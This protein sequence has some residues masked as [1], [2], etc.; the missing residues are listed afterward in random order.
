MTSQTAGSRCGTAMGKFRCSP[1]GDGWRPQGEWM[2]GGRWRER[3]IEKKECWPGAWTTMERAKFLSLEN[4]IL[5]KFEG[6]G[7]YGETSRMHARA[8]AES[9]W[10]APVTGVESGFIGYRLLNGRRA[11]PRELD[12]ER[13]QRIAA[14]C[15]FRAVEL[16]KRCDKVRAR[17]FDDHGESEFRAR[18]P[19]LDSSRF[20]ATGS[21]STD[22]L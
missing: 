17:R 15:A 16:R 22:T 18:I 21:S 11:A 12:S 9:G 8:L 4:Q 19:M 6:L 7:P 5:W 1:I 2:G 10:G 20:F 13:I 14:Y 3:F